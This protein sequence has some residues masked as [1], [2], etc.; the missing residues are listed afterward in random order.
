M[1]A[2]IELAILDHNYNTNQKQATT[3]KGK[4]LVFDDAL[5]KP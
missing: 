5:L 4:H 3:K 2:R 1:Q